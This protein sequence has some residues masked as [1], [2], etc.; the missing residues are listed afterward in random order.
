MKKFFLMTITGL[1]LSILAPAQIQQ[2]EI[3]YFQSLFGM[4]KKAVVANFLKLESNDPFWP[5]YDAYEKE[6]KT[7]SQERL[8]TIM[9]YVKNYEKLSDEKT[10]EL[11]SKSISSKNNANKLIAKYYKKIKKSSGSKTAAQFFQIENYFVSAINT[12]LYASLP[13]IGEL[14]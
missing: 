12:E 14:K 3:E 10:D 5:I 1:L 4:E 6:R 2:E 9:D 8:N 11:V 7:L 13:L